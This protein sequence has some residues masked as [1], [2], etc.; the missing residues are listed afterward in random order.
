MIEIKKEPHSKPVLCV[1]P[2]TEAVSES[3]KTA[4]DPFSNLHRIKELLKWITPC[5]FAIMGCAGR[6]P[7][8]EF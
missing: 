8:V 4:I 1:Y 6:C 3:K 2:L 7:L 5:F